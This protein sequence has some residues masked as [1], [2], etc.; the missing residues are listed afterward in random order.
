MKTHRTS[1]ALFLVE[2]V[3]VEGVLELAE[4][5]VDVAVVLLEGLQQGG[6][7]ALHL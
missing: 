4:L 7:L 2:L 1:V 6:R 5:E 3:L